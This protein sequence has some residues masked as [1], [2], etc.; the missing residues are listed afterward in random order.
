MSALLT[1]DELRALTG[2]RQPRRIARWLERNG[3]VHVVPARRGA[4]PAVDRGYYALRMAGLKPQHN[5]SG[6]PA[7]RL[8]RMKRHGGGKNAA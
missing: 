1:A 2:Y 7:L 8:D 6:E 3:W 5:S 4:I